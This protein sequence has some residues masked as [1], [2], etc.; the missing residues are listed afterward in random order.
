MNKPSIT[1]PDYF[2][3]YLFS[4]SL[5]GLCILSIST[6]K[7]SV[8]TISIPLQR[9]I[10]SSIF[11]AICVLGV[12]AGT[13]PRKCSGLIHF[14]NQEKSSDESKQTLTGETMKFVGHH[15]NCGK[16]FAH[17]VRLGNRTYCTGC[18]G[19]KLGAIISIIGSILYP[20]YGFNL[21]TI[22]V[23]IFWLGFVGVAIGLIHSLYD[24]NSG[25]ARLILNFTF[26]LGAFLLLIG[27]S[28]ISN[29]IILE[30]YLLVLIVYWIM[31]RIILS[32]EKHRRICDSCRLKSCGFS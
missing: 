29:N 7:A 5:F 25:R 3:F 9:Q 32:K 10:I 26:V 31:T 16:F 2:S 12:I 1:S 23:V 14:R 20:F 27:V 13:F 19:L 30:F 18:T 11:G 8:S 15:P 21:E 22:N 4:T 28:E 24:L 6:F 17:I